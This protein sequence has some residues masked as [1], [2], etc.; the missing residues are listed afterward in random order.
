MSIAVDA[1]GGSYKLEDIWK[2]TKRL[3]VERACPKPD[4]PDDRGSRWGG[5]MGI[6]EE[7]RR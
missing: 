1:T 6:I 5:D 2:N 3:S 4:I 7:R